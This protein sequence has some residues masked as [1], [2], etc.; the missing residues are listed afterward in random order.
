MGNK[1][2]LSKITSLDGAYTPEWLPSSLPLQ[3]FPQQDLAHADGQESEGW[4]RLH[5]GVLGTAVV[6]TVWVVPAGMGV[7]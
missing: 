2:A 6:S 4:R 1:I 7:G 3:H 5:G